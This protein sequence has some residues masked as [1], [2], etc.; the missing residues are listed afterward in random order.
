MIYYFTSLPLLTYKYKHMNKEEVETAD[1]IDLYWFKIYCMTQ[2]QKIT[3]LYLVQKYIKKINRGPF[4]FVVD[5]NWASMTFTS[6]LKWTF[7]FCSWNYLFLPVWNKIL[8]D[9]PYSF[10]LSKRYM[11]NSIINIYSLTIC[12]W[13]LVLLHCEP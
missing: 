11:S 13:T 6:G 12:T 5:K 1:L 10:Y 8:P 4:S 7:F 9:S 2:P 3:I